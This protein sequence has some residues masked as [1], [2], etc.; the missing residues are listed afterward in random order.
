MSKEH[1]PATQAIR[2]MKEKGIT[3]TLHQYKYIEHGGTEVSARELGID[4][5]QVVKTLIMED[6]K[7]SPFIV[8]MHGNRQVSTKNMAR[9]LGVKTVQICDP[10]VAEHHSG[11]KVGGTSPFGTRKQLRIFIEDTI[12]HLPEIYINAGLRGLLA[13]MAPSD[14]AAALDAKPVSVAIE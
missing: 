1:Y 8:L 2:V 3:F 7:K 13:K 6:E 5:Y 10:K 9:V 12:L 11:Y 4:E 14:L